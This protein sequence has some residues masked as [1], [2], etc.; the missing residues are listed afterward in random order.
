MFALTQAK[1][2][3]LLKIHFKKSALCLDSLSLQG[4]CL[5][6]KIQKKEGKSNL[7]RT[8][9]QHKNRDGTYL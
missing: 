4:Q 7:Q 6:S 5:K 2:K 3:I 9:N 8:N 1:E